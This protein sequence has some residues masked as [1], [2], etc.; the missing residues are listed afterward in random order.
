MKKKISAALVFAIVA[1]L[2]LTGAAVATGLDV[3]GQVRETK[4]DETSYER[5]GLLENVA[6]TVGETFHL[7]PQAAAN[8]RTPEN[9]REKLE[10]EQHDFAV[11]WT[12]D[13]VYCDG[14]KLYYSYTFSSDSIG[15]EMGEGRPTGFQK[16]DAYPGEK[17]GDT[18]HTALGKAAE[19]EA[20]DWLNSHEGGHVIQRYVYP[21]DAT[22]LADGTE[23]QIIDSGYVALDDNHYVGYNEYR[24]PE[25]YEAGK[26]IS[27]VVTMMS[28]TSV[29]HQDAQGVSAAY[30]FQKECMV[31]ATVTAPV[32]D[33]PIPYSSTFK[34]EEYEAMAELYVSDVD[35]SGS[36]KIVCPEEWAKVWEPCEDEA[37]Y[38]R[39]WKASDFVKDYKLV[40]NGK[41]CEGFTFGVTQRDKTSYTLDLRYDLPKEEIESLELI[42]IRRASGEV[43]EESI[44]VKAG[45]GEM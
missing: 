38:E 37:E 32:G 14:R 12:I 10:L 30:V 39:R 3:F 17:F 19:K 28:T 1:T 31:P 6:A 33:A 21:A 45:A 27:F 7:K 15:L 8:A 24:L 42:P 9:D 41:A 4:I 13:Q 26:E 43:P 34:T 11:D 22:L 23:L 36:V 40:V 5:L 20:A 35:I 18:L 44:T 25:G 16:W 2:A 29:F